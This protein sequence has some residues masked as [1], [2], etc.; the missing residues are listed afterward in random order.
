VVALAVIAVEMVELAELVVVHQMVQLEA[1]ELQI[2]D[3]QVEVLLD[4][5]GLIILLAVVVALALLEQIGQA[6]LLEMVEQV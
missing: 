6:A 4:L 2:K 5:E 1:L 3:L